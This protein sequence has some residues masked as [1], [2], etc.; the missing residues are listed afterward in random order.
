LHGHVEVAKRLELSRAGASSGRT[1][2][3]VTIRLTVSFASSASEAMRTSR[4]W[5]ATRPS[6]RV[7]AKVVLKALTTFA[8]GAL[9]AISCA[10]DPA[11]S[12]SGSKAST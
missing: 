11:S 4:G 1:P 8:P 3:S 2:A 5:P 12:L 7:P 6:P 9:A 10:A